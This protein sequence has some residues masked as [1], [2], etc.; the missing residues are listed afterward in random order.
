MEFLAVDFLAQRR[1]IIGHLDDFARRRL[2]LRPT[3]IQLLQRELRLGQLLQERRVLGDGLG[4]RA[5]RR[6]ELR[7]RAGDGQHQGV[8]LLSR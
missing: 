5:A 7:L 2:H 6:F 8:A 3:P 4:V 1:G